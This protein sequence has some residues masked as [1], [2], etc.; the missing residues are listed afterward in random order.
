MIS[1]L[2][3]LTDSIFVSFGGTLFQQ[4][5]GIPVGTNCAPLLAELFL[6][7]YQSEFL[8]NLVKNI[9]KKIHEARAFDFTYTDNI[10]RM[11]ETQMAQEYASV[12]L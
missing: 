1:M 2:E 11:I 8:Q 7:S 10:L 9:N 6:Y 12:R 4:V 5:V 3:I